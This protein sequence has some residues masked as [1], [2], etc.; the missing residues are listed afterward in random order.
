MNKL[1][2]ILGIT[3]LLFSLNI[4]AAE[5]STLLLSQ[6]KGG[7]SIDFLNSDNV[8]ALQFDI[9][10]SGVN[11]KSVGLNSCISG[12]PSSHTGTCQ[13][14]N[15][16]MRVVI[17]STSNATLESGNIGTINMKSHL[18]TDVSINKVVM[19]TSDLKEIKGDVL[20]DIDRIK[21]NLR[22]SESLK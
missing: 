21:P 20:V 10:M 7:Y 12:L 14:K 3:L 6:E 17:Y 16:V 18:A 13:I 2:K 8:T 11:D 15:G 1:N 5:R 22:N 19:G 4:V 9:K